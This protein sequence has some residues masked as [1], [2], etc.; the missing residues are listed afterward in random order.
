MGGG[1]SKTKTSNI[2]EWGANV[3]V[4]NESRIS[5]GSLNNVMAYR[6]GQSYQKLA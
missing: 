4:S 3:V 5:S 6:H 1:V 2:P